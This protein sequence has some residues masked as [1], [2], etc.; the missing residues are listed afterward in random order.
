M[1]IG[2]T[3]LIVNHANVFMVKRL[4]GSRYKQPFG[5]FLSSVAI[6]ADIFKNLIIDAID[7]INNVILKKY[8]IYIYRISLLIKLI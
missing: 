8:N 7:E 2:R 4:V 3:K 6:K 5:Y 1:L